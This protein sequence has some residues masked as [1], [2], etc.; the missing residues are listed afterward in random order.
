MKADSLIDPGLIQAYLETHYHVFSD[1]PFFLK[2]GEPSAELL[3]LHEAQGLDCSAY[4][5]AWNPFSRELEPDENN[6]RNATLVAELQARGLA[7]VQ[8]EGRHPISN[9]GEASFLI[10]GATRDEA[11]ALGDRHQQNAVVWCGSDAVPELVL[12]K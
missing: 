11:K 10:I 7:F 5:T 1:A 2:I 8:G 6:A 4:V 12:M 3:K 9:Y